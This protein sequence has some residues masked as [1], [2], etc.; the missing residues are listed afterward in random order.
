MRQKV[1]TLY[2]SKS[3][4]IMRQN[5]WTL[6][7]KTFG[8]YALAKVWT[9]CVDLDIMSCFGQKYDEKFDNMR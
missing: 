9:L 1:W 7:F 8:H 4:D 2:V 3:L 5:S 6:C